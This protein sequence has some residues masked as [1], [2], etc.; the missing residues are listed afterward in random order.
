[1]GILFEFQFAKLVAC[2]FSLLI[3]TGFLSGC[4]RKDKKAQG[5]NFQTVTVARNDLRKTVLST[6]NVQPENQLNI[7]P[8]ISGRVEEILIE[9]GDWVKSGQLLVRLSSTE[10]ATLLDTAKFQGPEILGKWKE[11]YN[12]TPLLSPLGGQIVYLPTVPGQYIATT[13]T[14][15]VLSDHLIVSTQVDETDLAQIHLNQDATIT[16]DAYPGRSVEGKVRR[17]AYQSVLVNNV[18]TFPVEVWPHKV[19]SF[20]RSGMTANVLFYV[21]EKKNVLTIPSEAV[22]QIGKEA[23]VLVPGAKSG[24][25]PALRPIKT[26]ETDGRETEVVSG[27]NEGDKI[28]VETFSAASMTPQS[29]GSNPFMP[30][31]R[32]GGGRGGR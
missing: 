6:G 19:P 31:I 17:I 13:D 11:Y 21:S 15:M 2:V 23:F 24:D 14:I 32:T 1:M 29:G 5:T 20:M 22:S 7:K 28:L 26:A 4:G 25:K 10:R 8:P 12:S 18:T 16:M 27:L 3:T 9:E 30:G